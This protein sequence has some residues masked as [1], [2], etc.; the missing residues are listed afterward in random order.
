MKHLRL[1][2]LAAL[3][4]TFVVPPLTHAADL[5]ITAANV[6][7]GARA[8]FVGGNTLA[9][10]TI[11]AGQL[12]YLDSTAGTFKLADAN[13][14]ATT[15]NVVGY[16][17]NSAS[18]GQYIGVVME[19]DDFTPGGTLSMTTGLYVLSATAGG[20]APS[21]DL[22]TGY[23]PAVVMIAKST[24]KAIFKITRG[25]AALSLLNPPHDS[26]AHRFAFGQRPARFVS[27]RR[28][29]EIALAA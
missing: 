18:A 15:A 14:S 25:S 23:Y 8:K 16:A 24:T 19:D 27:P 11:T 22:A 13:A 21:A 12:L 26:P 9:G 6:V 1:L 10:A 28:E 29:S 7:P 20:I 2:A 5:S 3:A 4:F 17:A